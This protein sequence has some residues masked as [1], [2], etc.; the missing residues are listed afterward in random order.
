M[1]Y[2]YDQMSVPDHDNYE[3]YD[4]KEIRKYVNIKPFETKEELEDFIENDLESWWPVHSI[5]SYSWEP[6]KCKDENE[7]FDHITTSLNQSI[8]EHI[9][10]I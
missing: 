7:A 2:V 10:D 3:Y 8:Y 9:H 5:D 4:I 6:V 1:Y